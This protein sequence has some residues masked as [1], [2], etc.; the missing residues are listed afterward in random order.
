MRA[1]ALA[2]RPQAHVD[3]ESLA[4]GCDVGEQRNHLAPRAHD[5]LGP[6]TVTVEEEYQVHIR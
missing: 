3:A 5:R 2:E 6:V 1:S 4:V